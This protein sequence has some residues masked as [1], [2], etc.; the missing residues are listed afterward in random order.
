MCSYLKAKGVFHIHD[1]CRVLL[2]IHEIHLYEHD[3]C[4]Y[5]HD[6]CSY[7]KAT[8]V[9]SQKALLLIG[10][11]PKDDVFVNRWYPNIT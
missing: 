3:K 8:G 9:F 10:L 11:F 1:I 5:E 7:V 6:I 4:R 2:R